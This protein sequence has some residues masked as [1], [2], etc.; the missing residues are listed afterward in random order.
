MLYFYYGENTYLLSKKK[1]EI[2]EK[3]REEQASLA[4]FD[5]LKNLDIA[6]L[7]Q[8]FASND[9]FASKKVTIFS[10]I[11]VN[12]DYL[13]AKNVKTVL[14]TVKGLAEN[15]ENQVYFFESSPDRKNPLFNYLKRKASEV[16]EFK[17]PKGK[18]MENFIEKEVNTLGIKVAGGGISKIC[19]LTNYQIWPTIN[20]LKKL[21]ALKRGKEIIIEDIE[22]SVSGEITNDIFKT[23]DALGRRDKKVAISLLHRH[24]EVGDHGL[25]LLSMIVYQFRNLIKVGDA[26]DQGI[27]DAQIP[28]LTKLHPFVVHKSKEFVSRIGLERLKTLYKKL[29]EIDY[30][31]KKGS[32]DINSALDL[33]ISFS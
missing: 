16:L 20:E 17:F 15:K 22:Q 28:G 30:S 32:L 21:D 18:D 10:D 12:D 33:F 6:Q 11:M 5:S 1:T 25:Y 24:L 7:D 19:F 9:F 31:V 3:A 14:K 2:R 13:E 4:F 23:I 26:L 27:S 29:A 8:L